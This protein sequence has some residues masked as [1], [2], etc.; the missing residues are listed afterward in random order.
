M[1]SAPVNQRRLDVRFVFLVCKWISPKEY[2][3]TLSHLAL[4]QPS[5]T[6]L[7]FGDM[8][9][10]CHFLN[11]LIAHCFMENTAMAMSFL[12]YRTSFLFRVIQSMLRQSES[13]VRC[14]SLAFP[15]TFSS[16][17]LY[18]SA[19]FTTPLPLSKPHLSQ[20]ERCW[21]QQPEWVMG[22]S[23]HATSK[24]DMHISHWHLHKEPL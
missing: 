18:L 12:A 20:R 23:F 9:C 24:A 2:T 10:F 8:S 21:C 5:S 7:F 13:L 17:P 15:Y 14:N 6:F 16:N 22:L 19:H 4:P 11:N 3:H 1:L